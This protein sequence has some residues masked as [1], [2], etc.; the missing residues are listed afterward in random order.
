MQDMD[1]AQASLLNLLQLRWK[2]T[3]PLCPVLVIAGLKEWGRQYLCGCQTR[4]PGLKPATQPTAIG[5]NKH[6]HTNSQALTWDATGCTAV[7]RN[8]Q[9]YEGPY[10]SL[11]T[12]YTKD[13]RMLLQ[14]PYLQHLAE[15]PHEKACV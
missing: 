5:I 4:V 14:V 3:H 8:A 6:R 15:I 1:G 2:I 13:F 11:Q 10:H 7:T 12:N 9:R